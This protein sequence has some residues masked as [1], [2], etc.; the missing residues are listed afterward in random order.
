MAKS[1]ATESR[2]GDPE[3]PMLIGRCVLAACAACAACAQQVDAPP[4]STLGLEVSTPDCE[5]GSVGCID[6]AFTPGFDPDLADA[7]GAAL[8]DVRASELTA[9]GAVAAAIDH[10]QEAWAAA[11]GMHDQ[12]AAMRWWSLTAYGSMMKT[13]TAA[14]ILRLRD[15][16]ALRLDDTLDRFNASVPTQAGWGFPNADRITVRHLLSMT[17]G[18]PDPLDDYGFWLFYLVCNTDFPTTSGYTRD[19][20]LASTRSRW[21]QFQPGARY[22]YNNIN[23]VLLSLIAE[24]RTGKPFATALRDEVLVPAQL[25]STT[26]SHYPASW[27]A[28]GYDDA[29]I[30]RTG[31]TGPWPDGASGVIASG[32]DAIEFWWR[33]FHGDIISADSVAEM[34]RPVANAGPGSWYGLGVVISQA[35]NGVRFVNHGGGVAGFTAFGGYV[36]AADLVIVTNFTEETNPITT[37]WLLG[38]EISLGVRLLG[39][40]TPWQNSTEPRDVVVDGAIAVP[41]RWDVDADGRVTVADATVVRA[42]LAAAGERVL[43][44]PPVAPDAP[45]PWGTRPFFDVDG[46]GALTAEDANQVDRHLAGTC[47]T[48]SD[49]ALPLICTN[50]TC[51]APPPP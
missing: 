40:M 25:S 15:R 28:T 24:E 43:P 50:A 44:N 37:P 5:P 49:C 47:V 32:A 22:D 31:C 20:V 51:T 11:T 21:V 2:F 30:R 23:Y 8:E 35:S 13:Y 48:D 29:G 33:L 7:L 9:R 46:D 41:Q 14:L 3:V 6:Q 18:L 45:P 12:A 19:V 4:E 38:R 10:R 16:G 26:V 42:E 27:Y 39:L 34:I 36:P 17:S 1:Q